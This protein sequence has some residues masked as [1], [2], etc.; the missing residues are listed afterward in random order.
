[1]VELSPTGDGLYRQGFAG[2]T[3]N[4]AW[5]VRALTSGNGRK[6]R[7]VSAVGS[8]ALSDTMFGFLADA[9]IDT[10]SMTRFEDRTVG[11][12]LITLTG[13][14]RSFTY[15]RRDSAA[16]RLASDVGRLKAALDGVGVAY[17]S[18]ITLAILEPEDRVR[19][20]SVL[21]TFRERGGE[22]VF[23]P[24]IRPRLWSDRET[25]ARVTTDG[26]RA[27][28]IALPT[29]P[30]EA[31]VYGDASPSDTANRIAAL[32]VREVVVKNG[33]DP[34]LLRVAGDS[35]ATIAARTEVQP[36]D[37]TG[38]G[39]SFNGGYIAARLAGRSPI[40]AARLGHAVAARVI[41]HRGALAPFT[42]VADLGT[43]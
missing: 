2:D 4:T 23:D 37:T 18:G 43:F 39:D 27:A 35:D 17:F 12:Y 13:A 19:L 20:L 34:V 33:S 1:M 3:L 6:V 11:L 16:R 41:R 31:D 25:M 38:A 30:D 29:F 40:E 26:Y 14:E 7:Y 8:D 9:G 21:S 22:V 36:I 10:H 15:W 28:T 42:S 32:G 24:N 5:Y